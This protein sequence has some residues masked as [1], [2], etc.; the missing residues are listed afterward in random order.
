MY[1]SSLFFPISLV[2]ISQY[3][4]V[5]P[6]YWNTSSGVTTFLP[7]HPLPFSNG[8]GSYPLNKPFGVISRG[9]PGWFGSANDPENLSSKDARLV[10]GEKKS[11]QQ[12]HET[13]RTAFSVLSINDALTTRLKPALLCR[14]LVLGNDELVKRKRLVVVASA[15]VNDDA[16]FNRIGKK[17]DAKL[18]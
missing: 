8:T 3:R 15:D 13:T 10:A 9:H 5:F 7:R 2:W 17:S 6:G 4:M 16:I 12:Q 18:G 1:I 14:L 11:E